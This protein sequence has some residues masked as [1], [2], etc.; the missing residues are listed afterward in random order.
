MT[1]SE[2]PIHVFVNAVPAAEAIASQLSEHIIL[3][4]KSAR[5][6]QPEISHRRNLY[7]MR[8]KNRQYLT[9][10]AQL[11]FCE[12]VEIG[13]GSVREDDDPKCGRRT[14]VYT[15]RRVYVR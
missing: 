10:L 6:F 5:S 2:D 3:W 4:E 9:A 15:D 8:L 13:F 12:K 11:E 14:Y 1:A 7:V